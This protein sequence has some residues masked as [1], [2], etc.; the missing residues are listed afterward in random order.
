MKLT[1]SIFLASD[2]EE[3]LFSG[4]TH[5]HRQ[6]TV[7]HL[8]FEEP[9][10]ELGASLTSDCTSLPTSLAALNMPHDD[11]NIRCEVSVGVILR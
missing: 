2:A 8:T 10:V 4:D 5:R 7:A 3:V 11:S 1:W 6:A 9:V